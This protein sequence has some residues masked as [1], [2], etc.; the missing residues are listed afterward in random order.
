MKKKKP[1]KP[2]KHLVLNHSVQLDDFFLTKIR[3]VQNFHV[4]ELSSTCR[5]S[6]IGKY[7]CYILT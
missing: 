4:K 1:K 3:E 7:N 2:T 6:S 5:F